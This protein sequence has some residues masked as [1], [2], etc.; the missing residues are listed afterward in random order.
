MGYS[1][2][3]GVREPQE[4]HSKEFYDYIMEP[5]NTVKATKSV[6]GDAEQAAEWFLGYSDRTA[7]RAP[8]AGWRSSGPAAQPQQLIERWMWSQAWV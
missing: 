5:A 4:A 7:G 6:P 1:D 2:R 8:A 3:A